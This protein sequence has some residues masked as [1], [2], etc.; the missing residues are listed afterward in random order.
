VAYVFTIPAAAVFFVHLKTNFYPQYK[1]FYRL[2]A[3]K[4]TL[5]E[6]SLAKQG[7]AAAAWSGLGTM[8]KLQALVAMAAL[9]VAPSLATFLHL[10]PSW[11]PLFRVEVLA[12]GGQF[13]ML[14]AILLLLYLDERRAA[15]L[16]TVVFAAG[17]TALTGVTVWLGHT[18][19]GGGYL[20][21]ALLAAF[22]ALSLLHEQLQRLEYRTFVRQPVEMH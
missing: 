1:A 15:L 9:L 18:T 8:V 16:V 7:M 13:L 5:K 4:G 19:Y 22:L 17:N 21:A 11:V 3:E 20:L 14:S 6:I 12:A 10:P 2:I